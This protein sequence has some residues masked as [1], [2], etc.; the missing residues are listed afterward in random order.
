MKTIN[1]IKTRSR[2]PKAK[3]NVIEYTALKELNDITGTIG[4]YFDDQRTAYDELRELRNITN[5]ENI[6]L[7]SGI[8]ERAEEVE[9]DL[10][11]AVNTLKGLNSRK[12][13]LFSENKEH[14]LKYKFKEFSKPSLQS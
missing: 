7:V 5:D 6:V 4:N 1:E 3:D 14:F 9:G 12:E 13:K 8:V 10:E 11:W 2:R